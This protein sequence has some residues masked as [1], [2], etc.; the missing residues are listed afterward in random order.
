MVLH[1]ADL[2]HDDALPG[3]ANHQTL[4]ALLRWGNPVAPFIE[5]LR[6]I[7]YEGVAPD[8]ATFLYVLGVTVI[9]AARRPRDLQADGGRAGGGLVTVPG[10]VVLEDASRASRSAAAA[11]RRSRSASPARAASARSVRALD[12]VTLRVGPG[13]TLGLMGRNGAGKTSTLRCW[14]ASSRWTPAA[15]SA[16][17]GLAR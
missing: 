17:D 2:L 7:L 11:R 16:A 12:G 15:R 13:E 14:P 5:A 10:E 9:A 6:A 1:H 8:L 4:E 3:L